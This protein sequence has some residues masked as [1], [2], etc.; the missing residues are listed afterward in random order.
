M[1]MYNRPKKNYNATPLYS[2]DY[3]ITHISS[4]MKQLF[5]FF[6]II[7][8]FIAYKAYDIY[9]ATGVIIVATILQVLYAWIKHR[10][11][12]SNA[13]TLATLKSNA[14]AFAA[15]LVNELSEKIGTDLPKAQAA[16]D[17]WIAKL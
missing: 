11:P 17:A 12:T 6:P 2:N 14:Q 8:F 4:F 15:T 7:L 10:K 16:L 3:F 13:V 5:E 9:I 1:A